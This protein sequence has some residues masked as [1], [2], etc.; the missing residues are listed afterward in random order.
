MTIHSNTKECITADDNEKGSDLCQRVNEVLR[1]EN[2]EKW[3]LKKGICSKIKRATY[4]ASNLFNCPQSDPSAFPEYDF[5]IY[6]K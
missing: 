1:N 5:Y 2:T 6:P 4:R 3:D